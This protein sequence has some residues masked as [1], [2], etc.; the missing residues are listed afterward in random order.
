MLAAKRRA[1]LVALS[2]KSRRFREGLLD[3]DCEERRPLGRGSSF[4]PT[5]LQLCTRR[6]VGMSLST[7]RQS[8]GMEGAQPMLAGTRRKPSSTCSGSARGGWRCGQVS[9]MAN[10]WKP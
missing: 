10:R 6:T 7:S 8:T 3:V 1:D 2:K 5:E 4:L 9:L